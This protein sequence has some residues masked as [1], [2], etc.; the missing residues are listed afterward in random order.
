M[1]SPQKGLRIIL[2]TTYSRL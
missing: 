1:V 2:A